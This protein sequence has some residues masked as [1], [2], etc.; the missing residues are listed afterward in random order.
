MHWLCVPTITAE[1]AVFVVD[2]PGISGDLFH[3]TVFTQGCH[4]VGFLELLRTV[5]AT[6]KNHLVLHTHT[7]SW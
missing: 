4:K 2:P 7:H 6:H 3:L 5:H 1:E